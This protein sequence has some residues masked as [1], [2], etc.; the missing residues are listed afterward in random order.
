MTRLSDTLFQPGVQ[1]M[2]VLKPHKLSSN[3]D[4]RQLNTEKELRRCQSNIKA[5]SHIFTRKTFATQYSKLRILSASMV[6]KNTKHDFPVTF[7]RNSHGN[8]ALSA[9]F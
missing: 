8:V 2:F 4:P 7:G 9:F 6:K 3:Q 1:L 5:K